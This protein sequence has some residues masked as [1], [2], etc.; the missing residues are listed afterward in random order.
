MT[1]CSASDVRD[2][3][4]LDITASTSD[5]GIEAIIDAVCLRID[6][7]SNLPAGGYAVTADTTRRYD[8]NDLHDGQLHLDMSLLS[9]TSLTNG[10]G[11]DLPTG[12]YRLYP[13]N[14]P[15]KWFIGLLSGYGWGMETDGEIIVTGKFGHSLTV[16]PNIAEAATMWSA[17]LVKRYQGAL[18]DATANQDLGQ[19]VYSEAIPKQVMALL[20][21]R[22]P[23]L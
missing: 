6:E 19:L 5:A 14:T 1:Y 22:G 20:R 10:D 2:S 12:S 15:Q 17:Y 7:F 11:S 13:R 3:A 18:Q 4:R 16:P 9:L 8:W 21:G 23:M